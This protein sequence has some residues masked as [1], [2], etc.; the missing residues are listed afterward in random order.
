MGCDKQN[1]VI[2]IFIGHS[3]QLG[4]YISYP[5]SRS[6]AVQKPKAVGGSRVSIDIKGVSDWIKVTKSVP[7]TRGKMNIEK[8][9]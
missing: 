8:V 1:R 9:E 2:S 3:P 6:H 5:Y 4:C 7:C